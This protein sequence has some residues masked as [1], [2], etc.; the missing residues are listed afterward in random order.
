[1]TITYVSSKLC[2]DLEEEC[3]QYYF[4]INMC[5]FL[6][7]FSLKINVY[8]VLYLS[9]SGN[10]INPYIKLVLTQLIDIINRPNT[11]K[12][13]LENTGKFTHGHSSVCVICT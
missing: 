10:D 2:F 1:M 4:I 13:L 9:V 12:T 3:L 8:L 5:I 7:I 6:I 11:P